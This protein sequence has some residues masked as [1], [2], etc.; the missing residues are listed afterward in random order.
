[1]HH[2]EKLLG[3]KWKAASTTTD[4]AFLPQNMT[5]QEYYWTEPP[6]LGMRGV[7]IA[8]IIDIDEAG[9]FLEHSD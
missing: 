4:L 5:L 8:D 2:A 1:V 3:L 7:P 6:P 9:F